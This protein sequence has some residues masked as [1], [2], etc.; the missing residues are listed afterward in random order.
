[1]IEIYCDCSFDP[2]LKIAGCAAVSVEQGKVQNVVTDVLAIDSVSKAETHA[3]IMGLELALG[4]YGR[5]E[6][7]VYN[8][9][10]TVVKKFQKHG[11]NVQ[12][13]SRNENNIADA[14]AYSCRV[15]GKPI[16]CGE[17]TVPA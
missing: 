14:L 8:D 4:P 5:T 13:I 3:I 12:W 11:I 17:E 15:A 9:N 16:R 1:M 10:L 2:N 7:K 6:T